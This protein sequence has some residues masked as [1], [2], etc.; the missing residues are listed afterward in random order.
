MAAETPASAP[1]RHRPRSFTVFVA[2]FVAGAA[3][4]VGVNRALDVHL[5]QAK[6]QVECEPIFVA[7]RS[8]PQGVPVTVWDVAL[9]DWPKAMLPS[10]ALRVTDSFEGCLLKYPLREGQPLLAAQLVKPEPKPPA[11]NEQPA[12][13]EGAEPLVEEAFVPPTPAT[14]PVAKIEPAAAPVSEKADER[15]PEPP[16]RTA[17]VEPAPAAAPAATEPAAVAAADESTP[18]AVAGQPTLAGPATEPAA[19]QPELAA[20]QPE[21]AVEQPEPAVAAAMPVPSLDD[22][23]STR[24]IDSAFD[25][26]DMPSRPA[27]DLA[28]IPSVMSQ[29]DAAAAPSAEETGTGSSIRYLVVPERIARQAD[30]SFTT[31]VAPEGRPAG[32]REQATASQRAPGTP[33]A[34]TPAPTKPAARPR[35]AASQP[36][37]QRGQQAQQAQRGQPAQPRQATTRQPQAKQQ[38]VGQPGTGQQARPAPSRS[39]SHQKPATSGREEPSPRAWGGMFPNVSAGLEAMGGWRGRVREAAVPQNESARP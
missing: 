11:A 37:A 5:S 10:T 16:A 28:Q 31:P 27:A 1:A 26:A 32:D 30:T 13:G 22:S 7:L 39:Q 24:S 3:A 21:L 4:A 12:A 35:T 9:R 14:A 18:P 19:Q 38:Q 2:A 8:L 29:A 15:M 34:A 17:A 25:V 6:P 33:P 36:Q 23:E 20:G